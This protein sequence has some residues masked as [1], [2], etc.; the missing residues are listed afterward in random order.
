MQGKVRKLNKNSIKLPIPSD[1][2]NDSPCRLSVSLYKLR[3]TSL[4][5]YKLKIFFLV[6]GNWG[7]WSI[8][9][10]C[11]KTCGGGMKYRNRKCDN[12]AP[13]SG[14]KTCL[15][16]AL[17][18]QHCNTQTCAGKKFECLTFCCLSVSLLSPR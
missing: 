16:P 5:T 15:G 4:K 2:G 11:T 7:P 3:I 18:A 14:G 1:K 6:D 12:P 17:Q 10:Q 9:G 13:A 8:F